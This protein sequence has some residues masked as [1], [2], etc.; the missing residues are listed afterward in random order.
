MWED[1]KKGNMAGARRWTEV[2]VGVPKE[3]QEAVANFLMEGGSSGLVI[4]E[5]GGQGGF[6]Y[7]TCSN[8]K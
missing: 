4:E 3:A 6:N 2:R 1:R 5:G 8:K 7:I